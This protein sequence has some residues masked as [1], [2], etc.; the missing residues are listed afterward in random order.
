MLALGTVSLLPIVS[1]AV[2]EGLL[3][4]LRAAELTCDRAALL[5]AQVGSFF[6]CTFACRTCRVCEA[7]NCNWVMLVVVASSLLLKHP[8][9]GD[10]N[11]L[12][13]RTPRWSFP[14]S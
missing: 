2:E 6:R 9:T 1:S 12:R 10:P 5:V 3:R 8:R 11:P 7:L 4:W 13:N 14:C